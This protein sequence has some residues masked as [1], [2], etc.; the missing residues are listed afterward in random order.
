L[1]ILILANTDSGLYHFRYELLTELCKEHEVFV[2]L[3]Q[4][5]YIG[6]FEALGCTFIRTDF[7]RRSI[8]PFHDLTLL[9]CYRHILKKVRPDAVLSYT[10]K[11]NIYGGIACRGRDIPFLPNVTG[12]GT[13]IESGGLLSRLLMFAYRS[14][15]K[16]AHSIF[17][18]NANNLERLRRVIPTNT[19]V[20]LIPGSGV[21]L[22]RFTVKAYPS[23]DEPIR[24]LFIGRVMRNKG[25]EELMEA[26]KALKEE[27]PSTSLDILGR[28]DENYQGL[29][30]VMQ[31]QGTLRYH[32]RVDDVRPYIEASHCTVHPSYHEGMSNVLLESAASGRPVIASRVPGCQE[33]FDEAV[34]GFGCEAGDSISLLEAMRKFV[35]LP[36]EQKVAM[37]QAGRRKMEREFNRTLVIN[38]Y[39]E[40]LGSIT[41]RGEE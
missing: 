9:R 37:G 38:A 1:R 18:Q 6:E 29:L 31:D 10:I 35:K 25:I 19:R 16:K 34:S 36:Y 7:K 26:M 28:C 12:L 41:V 23:P 30:Q 24:F 39:I 8:N 40:E 14:A 32:G 15:F 21:N 17:F 13:A 5:K 22:D 2:S 20:R 33:T 3:P 4:G 27:F 11:P